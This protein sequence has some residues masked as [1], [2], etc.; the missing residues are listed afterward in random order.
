MNLRVAPHRPEGARK[1]D[2]RNLGPNLLAVQLCIFFWLN[3][4]RLMPPA[5][6]SRNFLTRNMIF[7]VRS[8]LPLRFTFPPLLFLPLCTPIPTLGG[9]WV[10]QNSMLPSPPPPLPVPRR[11]LSSPLPSYRSS[12]IVLCSQLTL[13][14]P[15]DPACLPQR[16]CLPSLSPP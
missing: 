10:A 11:V 6:D 8:T 9:S 16:L 5:R 12:F 4:S 2:S 7:R 1:Q 14:D 13:G 3:D 15:P